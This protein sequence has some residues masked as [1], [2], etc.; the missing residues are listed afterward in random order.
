MMK[1]L[2][3]LIALL[4]ISF[5]GMESAAQTTIFDVSGSSGLPVT[6][7]A[8]NNTGT[9]IDRGSYLL[10][11]AAS[12]EP[13]FITTA[14]YD[15]SAFLTAKVFVDVATFGGGSTNPLTIQVSNNGVAFST[16]GTS[17]TPTSSSYVRDNEIVL[18]SISARTIIRFVGGASGRGVRIQN[19]KLI[20]DGTAGGNLAPSITNISNTPTAPESTDAVTISADV[21]DSDGVNNVELQYGFA[22]GVY[23]QTSIAMTNNIGDTYTA[24]IAEQP[25][26]TT[27]FYQIVA[28]DSNA[29]PATATSA[30]QSYM[31]MDPVPA[32]SLIITEVADPGDNANARF[33][34][35]YNN[36]AATIDFSVTPVYLGRYANSNTTSENEQL[37]GTLAPGSYLVIAGSG[38]NF[39]SA[40]GFSPDAISGAVSG[41]GDD[42][43]ALFAGSSGSASTLFDVYGE[44]GTDGS[45]ELWEYENG[46][47]V[48]NSVADMPSTVWQDAS[49]T[50][51]S[52]NVTDM[53]PG[54][55]ESIQ[56]T[57]D[58]TAWTPNAPSDVAGK[59]TS[60]DD[61][62]VLSGSVALIGDV[63]IRNITVQDGTTL[64]L[65]ANAINLK[66]NFN[67]LGLGTIA[68]EEAFLNFGGVNAQEI[69]ASKITFKNLILN[70]ANGLTLNGVVSLVGAL[71]LTN[72]LLTSNDNLIMKSSAGKSAILLGVTSGSITGNVTVE[73][74]YP[75]QRAF[76]FV[77]SPVTM[78]GTIFSNWQQSGLN[79]GGSGYEAGLGTAITGGDLS[80]GF[81]QST[82]NNPSAFYYDNI[83]SVWT[84]IPNTNDAITGSL[85]AGDAIRLYIRGDRGVSLT[86]SGQTPIDT[87]LTTYGTLATGDVEVTNINAD[88]SNFSLIGNPYQAQVDFDA[89]LSDPS[90]TNDINTNTFFVWDPTISPEGAYVA[91]NLSTGSNVSGSEVNQFIQPN[92]AIFVS[93]SDDAIGGIIPRITFKESFKSSSS[94]TTGVYSDNGIQ[95]LIR[96]SIIA[97]SDLASGR[98][99]DGVVVRFTAAG[100][101]SIDQYDFR[102]M[103]NP[104]ENLSIFQNSSD[105]LTISEMQIPINGQEIAFNLSGL[106]ED[107]YTFQ[108]DNTYT[109]S[110]NVYFYDAFLNINTLLSNGVNTISKAFDRSEAGSM[111]AS[112]F[113][114]VFSDQT[115]GFNEVSNSTFSV[116]PNPLGDEEVLM[117]NNLIPNE[118]LTV[119]VYNSTG[120]LVKTYKNRT[121]N[122]E[123][124][125]N[126]FV[127]LKKGVYL[128][129]LNQGYNTTTIKLLKK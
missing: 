91:Y 74:F 123:H 59:S 93:T 13:D 1:K 40:Y 14:S 7:S 58:G 50:I 72:G 117:V 54:E 68:G 8:T 6:W 24:A 101:N 3:Y 43:Y 61:I 2:Y 113:K 69:N 21:T 11:D 19:L 26:G 42:T 47:A 32:P 67:V 31:V 44:I 5:V 110:Q 128:V 62:D 105:H 98:G 92:Q 46:R 36:G 124:G 94:S 60:S 82:S 75:A 45:G 65:G 122:R 71:Q 29:S 27:V 116:Y 85:A 111:D 88:D 23:D 76:R 86:T 108:I 70:N 20:A 55:G 64:D 66:G 127:G 120:Q 57:Y 17:A 107:D 41:N 53:T 30:E 4:F 89:L 22:A 51:T 103:F 16:I 35:V 28:T 106:L 63:D 102:K 115:L 80:D 114:L 97:G 129:T 49:W 126:V 18:S 48:R 12:P 77:S 79:V 99:R 119:N 118:V 104:N 25:N 34:E 52:A 112:R 9:D 100:N 83:A 87:K 78:V 125:L 109:G 95:D 39:T 84:A 38:V 10:V 37:A 73:Q 96:V 33:V 15:L 56:Y 81:D 90:A 121:Q